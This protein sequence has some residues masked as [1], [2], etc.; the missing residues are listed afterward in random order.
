MLEKLLR[1]TRTPLTGLADR[2]R[3]DPR[4][5]VI[6]H[7]MASRLTGSGRNLLA[8][9]GALAVIGVGTVAA[10]AAVPDPD[11]LPAAAEVGIGEALLDRED[12]ADRADR[13]DR[14]EPA[15]SEQGSGRDSD[16]G[17]AKGAEPEESP[18]PEPSPAES[19]ESE[20]SEPESEAEGDAKPAASADWVHPMPGA[21]TT[22]CFGWRSGAMHAGV[23]LADP[24]GTPIRAVGAGTVTDAGWVFGGYGISVVIDHGNGYFTHYAHASQA[25]V[26]PGNR[27]SPGQTIAL[28]GSTGDSSGPH[29][30]FEVHQGMW[31]QVEPTA[32][33]RSRGVDIGGC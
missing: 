12:G 15:G 23:D 33:L 14:D 25:N 18:E 9:A 21:S 13:G 30:H 31:N 20:E 32:W 6:R 3:A 8:V 26:S 11:P 22:S 24:P 7:R 19:E 10:N 4:I 5:D 1:S 28:E 17:S 27:V 16:P 29:L 2:A